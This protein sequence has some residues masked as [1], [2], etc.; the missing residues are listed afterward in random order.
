MSSRITLNWVYPRPRG[1]TEP[2]DDPV[3]AV[4]G[5]SPPT[6]GNHGPPS[7]YAGSYGSIP[8]HAG[9]PH[10]PPAEPTHPRVYPRPRGGTTSRPG[11]WLDAQGLSP[12]TRGNLPPWPH[13]SPCRR[14]IPAHAGEPYIAGWEQLYITVY[15]RPRGGTGVNPIVGHQETGLSP[16]TRGNLGGML[17]SDATLGS[18]PAHAG[19]PRQGSSRPTSEALY[20]R[21]RGG[22]QGGSTTSITRYGLS[23]PTRGNRGIPRPWERV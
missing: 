10:S 4:Y 23:P 2:S 1:G 13:G 22:T 19:E 12:P 3:R 16:P 9:E 21:P 8:A 18:I 14:S 5:L 6:R 11:Y 15:P 17:P 20:P 7:R